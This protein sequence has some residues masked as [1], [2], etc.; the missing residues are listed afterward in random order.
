MRLLSP[1]RSFDE[2][3]RVLVTLAL[4]VV[5]ACVPRPGTPPGVRPAA[6]PFVR[7]PY[8]QTVEDDRAVIRWRTSPEAASELRW[9]PAGDT[10]WR[11]AEVERMRAG[12]RRVA[13]EGLPR[14]AAVEYRVRSRGVTSG[15]WRF[16]T[17]PPD[18]ASGPVRILAFGDSGWGSEPQVALAHRMIEGPEDGSWDLAVHVGDLAYP[19]GRDRDFTIRHFRVYAPLLARLPLHPVAGNHDVVA[20]GGEAY[21]RAFGASGSGRWWSLRRGRVLVVGLD[22]SHEPA[23]DSL[24]RREGAQ[25]RWLDRTLADAARDTTLAWTVVVLHHPLYSHAVGLS[26]HGSSGPLREAVEPLLLRHGVDLVLAG[27]DHHY[28]R[29]R[30]VREGRP[31]APGCGPVHLVTGGGGASRYARSVA[32]D[33]ATA[34]ASRSHHYVTLTLWPGHGTGRAVDPDG[35]VFD[36]FRLVPHEA[37]GPSCD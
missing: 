11:E 37:D 33:P 13:L 6:D 34:A 1:Q 24:A 19:D 31:A 5:G 35:R 36:R 26:G 17:P 23:R 21:D 22:T 3:H 18:T 30:P 16:E 27:H 12:D 4:L 32:P 25:W 9:R 14:A 10:A 15:P 28:E 20:E 29:S 7:L 2:D 8:L